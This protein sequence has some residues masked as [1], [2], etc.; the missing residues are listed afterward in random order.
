MGRF[1]SSAKK[2]KIN[3]LANREPDHKT[4]VNTNP[5]ALVPL[6]ESEQTSL[7]NLLTKYTFDEN[8]LTEDLSDL[9]KITSE[10]K[11]ISNQAIVLHGERIKKAQSILKK[12]SEGAF[13]QW[14]LDTYGNRQTPYNFMQYYDFYQIIPK[15]LKSII[16]EMPRQAI[17]SLSSRSITNEEKIS[18]IHSYNGESKSELLEKIREKFPLPTKDKR[19]P[20]KS[21]YIIQTLKRVYKLMKS[22][23]FNP[24]ERQKEEIQVCLKKISSALVKTHT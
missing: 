18:F 17:Y 19:S 22:N 14:L 5:F 3:K 16:D 20:K 11:A 6:S 9:T 8:N 12:Y 7:K 2:E 21:A 15:S 23:A 10:I 13:S 1:K 24:E 4:D